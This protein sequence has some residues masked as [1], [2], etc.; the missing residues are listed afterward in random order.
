MKSHAKTVLTNF[1]FY[2]LKSDSFN[3]NYSST[4][5]KINNVFKITIIVIKNIYFETSLYKV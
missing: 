3:H 4:C 5:Q 2:K 1:Y